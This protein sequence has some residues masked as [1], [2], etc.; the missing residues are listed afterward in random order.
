[1]RDFRKSIIIVAIVMSLCLSGCG[2][3]GKKS[4]KED[5]VTPTP[6][7]Y[8]SEKK[9][10]PT[11]TP[12][13]EVTPTV[14]PGADDEIPTETVTPTATVSVTG[15][16][17]TLTPVP[18]VTSVGTHE[19]TPV[20]KNMYATVNLKVREECN[21]SSAQIGVV[22]YGKTVF[23][24]GIL[25]NGWA[26]VDFNGKIAYVHSGYLSAEP[27]SEATP[28]PTATATPNAVKPTATAT[29]VPT[30]VADSDVYN[31]VFDE[32]LDRAGKNY[33]AVNEDVAADHLAAIN[34]ERKRLNDAGTAM[35][36][37]KLDDNLNKVAAYRCAELVSFNDANLFSHYHPGYPETKA[38]ACAFDVYKFYNTTSYTYIAENI[39][40]KHA[41]GSAGWQYFYSRDEL[42]YE[43]YK[44]FE[45]SSGHYANMTNA[46]YTKIGICFYIDNNYIYVVQIFG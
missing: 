5:P 16:A 36:Q 8:V 24:Y 28:V 44:Q 22:D 43:F 1:M 11:A 31:H 4:A 17:V 15:S 12:E 2:K 37:L 25:E 9:N 10:T 18:S 23:V 46:N 3:A 38:N 19:E 41:T 33:L 26:R 13:D 32:S 29:P 42:G 20:S 34:A 27:V 35:P 30:K 39:A 45:A 6:T 7:E 14:T 40:M 21:S